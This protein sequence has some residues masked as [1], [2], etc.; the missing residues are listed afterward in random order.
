[1]VLILS[2]GTHPVHGTM[3]P[4]LAEWTLSSDPAALNFPASSAPVF[5][6]PGN[7]AQEL[8]VRDRTYYLIWQ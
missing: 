2:C 3:V 6:K 5:W 4:N 8:G 7:F 1:M